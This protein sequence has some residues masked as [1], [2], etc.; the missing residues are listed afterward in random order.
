MGRPLIDFGTSND[1]CAK[2]CAHFS[3][4]RSITFWKIFEFDGQ[5]LFSGSKSILSN[6][7]RDQW[8][9]IERFFQH[10]FN[11]VRS[12]PIW[13]T[14]FWRF[15]VDPIRFDSRP[16]SVP[17]INIDFRSI[18]A[19]KSRQCHRIVPAVQ[20][21]QSSL[22][23]NRSTINNGVDHRSMVWSVVVYV[24]FWKLWSRFRLAIVLWRR[25]TTL[26]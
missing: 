4:T 10:H 19:R 3:T 6:G 12:V 5:S 22:D 25:M 18:L 17:I 20:F 14:A 23:E 26:F 16:W 9:R 2:R 24:I 21:G 11:T 8:S 7:A 1:Q 13:S 15:H